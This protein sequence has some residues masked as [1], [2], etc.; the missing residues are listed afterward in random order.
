M[1]S[2]AT[3]HFNEA[4]LIPD[5]DSNERENAGWIV[6]RGNCKSGPAVVPVAI[7]RPVSLLVSHLIA[8][9]ILALQVH[10]RINLFQLIKNQS[11]Q[12]CVS[13]PLFF[14]IVLLFAN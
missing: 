11:A 2:L 13:N 6:L 3:H 12:N 8:L 14:I 5:R 7:I 1:F 4:R 10:A 9:L